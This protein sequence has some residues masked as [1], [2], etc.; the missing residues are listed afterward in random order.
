MIPAERHERIKSELEKN[1]F[2][3]VN[4]LAERLGISISTVRR[5][6]IDLENEGIVIRSRGGAG[7]AG[8]KLSL[9]AAQ[10]SRAEQHITQKHKIGRKAAELI[11]NS[12][13]A[14]LDAGTTTLEVARCLKPRKPLR[15][16]T[17]SIEIAYEL[18]DRENVTVLVTGGILRNES[19]NLYGGFGEYMLNAMHAQVCV[20]GASGLTLRE[21]LTK[22]D[23][24]AL[25]IRQKMIEISHDLVCLADSS[26]FDV[27]GL[28][29]ICPIDRVDTLIT[30]NGIKPEF[31]KALEDMGIEVIIAE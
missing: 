22:H 11:E 30:D 13:C 7:L 10:S 15:I 1:G 2:A 20:M 3:S 29:S 21:G 18:R 24:E 5:D 28:V 16:I 25:P 26:K 8:H 12:G 27:T 6:L 4:E 19:Y 31:K 17:D 23:I 9:P 14:I